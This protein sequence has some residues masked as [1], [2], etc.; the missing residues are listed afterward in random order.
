VDNWVYLMDI[1][2][3]IKFVPSGSSEQVSRGLQ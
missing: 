1:I 3:Y 2:K